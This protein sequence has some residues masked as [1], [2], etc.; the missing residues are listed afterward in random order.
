MD[1]ITWKHCEQM[2]NNNIIRFPKEKFSTTQNLQSQE[3]LIQKI[4]DYKTSFADEISEILSNLVFGELAR[5]GVNFEE[6]IDELFPS[7]M[8]IVEAIRSLHLQASDIHH[9]LQDFALEI[10]EDINDEE[11]S[12]N[13]TEDQEVS[14]VLTPEDSVDKSEEQVY[15]DSITK[16]GVET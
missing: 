5:S 9:P 15:S 6:N 2:T 8:L 11:P 4:N 10:Y 7:M 13:T 16:D 12:S 1:Y 3:E 14:D